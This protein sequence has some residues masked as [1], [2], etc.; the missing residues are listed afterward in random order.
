MRNLFGVICFILW[1][2]IGDPTFPEGGRFLSLMIGEV[3]SY[4]GKG[5]SF[6]P[7]CNCFP[8]RAAVESTSL[9]R[10]RRLSQF[11][12]ELSLVR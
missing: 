11:M 3:G 8:D 9:F 6:S 1:R 2:E 12:S 5:D 7:V 10:R 4:F